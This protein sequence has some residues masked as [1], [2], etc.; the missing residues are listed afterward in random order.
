M[1]V[2]VWLKRGQGVY[3]EAAT[4]ARTVMLPSQE[5]RA[6]DTLPPAPRL[7]RA[8]RT[9]RVGGRRGRDDAHLHD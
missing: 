7:S 8:L 3:G 1:P 4:A 2:Y 9:N 5:Q 6:P